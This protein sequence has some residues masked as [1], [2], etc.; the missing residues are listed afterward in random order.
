MFFKILNYDLKQYNFRYQL[1]LNIDIN[2]FN[3]RECENGLHFC[4]LEQVPL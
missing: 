1:G 4:S 2:S 3:D